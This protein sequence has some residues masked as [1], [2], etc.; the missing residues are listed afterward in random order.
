[1]KTVKEILI[2]LISIIIVT[3]LFGCSGQKDTNDID[4]VDLSDQLLKGAEFEDELS[5][6]DDTTVKKLYNIDNYV[7]ASVYISS[8]ATAEEIALFEFE[9]K[10]TTEDGMKKATDRIE[11]QKSDFESYIPKEIPKLDNAV[12]R[13]SGRYLLVCVSNSDKAEEIITQYIKKTE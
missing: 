13:Q 10:E 11:E 9:N 1:M 3:T 8:G 2:F 6:V 12:I 7:K 4:I 5:A